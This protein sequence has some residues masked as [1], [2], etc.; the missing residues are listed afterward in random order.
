MRTI[1]HFQ[2]RSRFLVLMRRLLFGKSTFFV[3]GSAKD[4]EKAV[5]LSPRPSRQVFRF[6]LKSIRTCEA[7]FGGPQCSG[8]WVQAY[9]YSSASEGKVL[10]CGLDSSVFCHQ[11]AC[12]SLLPC[13]FSTSAFV[14]GS[15]RRLPIKLR[16]LITPRLSLSTCAGAKFTLVIQSSFRLDS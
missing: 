16:V 8:L 6:Y 10:G 12:P 5:R 14:K 7:A 3:S 15:R 13:G 4:R 1:A 9:L 2:S 11:S